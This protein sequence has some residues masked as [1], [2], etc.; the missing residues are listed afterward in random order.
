M[1]LEPIAKIR[2]ESP[3]MPFKAYPV[4][5]THNGQKWCA[6]YRL[7]DA[8]GGTRRLSVDSAYGFRIATAAKD[9]K[10][11]AERLLCE[12]VNGRSGTNH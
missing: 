5:I 2:A 9:T 1:T 4:S 12:I 3:V 8:A 10:A 11:Q 6:S 7:D